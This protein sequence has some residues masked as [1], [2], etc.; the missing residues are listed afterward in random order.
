MARKTFQTPGGLWYIV[1]KDGNVTMNTAA[2]DPQVTMDKWC[3]R[4]NS[5]QW[6]EAI[7]QGYD[8]V[9]LDAT[10]KETSK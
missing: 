5:A 3:E 9:Q 1:D 2:T 4:N 6:G 7:K 8:V 10:F